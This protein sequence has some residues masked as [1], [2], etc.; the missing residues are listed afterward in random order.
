MSKKGSVDKEKETLRKKMLDM[1]KEEALEERFTFS[2]RE[3]QKKGAFLDYPA[4]TICGCDGEVYNTLMN[5]AYQNNIPMHLALDKF[6]EKSQHLL[7]GVKQRPKNA[8]NASMRYWKSKARQK[9]QA[10]KSQRVLK[11]PKLEH[12]G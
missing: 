6:M 2:I 1:L 9:P 11:L 12:L 5:W 10:K 7:E 8:D 4:R 3:K